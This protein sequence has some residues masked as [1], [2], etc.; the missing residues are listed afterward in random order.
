MTKEKS[1]FAAIH[2]VSIVEGNESDGEKTEI[3]T[4]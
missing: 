4:E 3:H 1:L 2:D